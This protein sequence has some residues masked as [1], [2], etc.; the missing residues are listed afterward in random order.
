MKNKGSF[1]TLLHDTENKN[2]TGNTQPNLAINTRRILY[3]R[4]KT[5]TQI[6]IYEG[7]APNT[8]Q[9]RALHNTHESYMWGYSSAP[10]NRGT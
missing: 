7:A 5:Q 2:D 3:Y 1:E 4:K 10:K 9:L 8:P 6:E